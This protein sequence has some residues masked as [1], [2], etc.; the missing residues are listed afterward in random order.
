MVIGPDAGVASR[1]PGGREP[2]SGR[3]SKPRVGRQHP[4]AAGRGDLARPGDRG[5]ADPGRG[6]RPAAPAA[7]GVRCSRRSTWRPGGRPTRGADPRR[8]AVGRG[9]RGADRGGGGLVARAAGRTAA[10]DH[11]RGA[12]A[13]AAGPAGDRAAP[14]LAR[15]RT[16]SPSSAACGWPRRPL[17]VLETA[18]ELGRPGA[19]LLDRALRSWLPCPSARGVPAH[20]STA[21]RRLLDAAAER[22][23][24]AAGRLLGRLLRDAGAGGWV[25]GDRAG[26]A[27]R[28]AG[29]RRRDVPGR[30]GGRRGHRLGS[31]RWTS[32]RPRCPGR[33]WTVLCV[34]R[35]RPRRAARARCWPRSPRRSA[36]CRTGPAVMSTRPRR[37]A[38]ATPLDRGPSD[39]GRT[40]CS[41][42]PGRSPHGS[43][44]VHHVT[45]PARSGP[46]GLPVCGV[47]G[48]AGPAVATGRVGAPTAGRARR[49]ARIRGPGIPAGQQGN[50][51]RRGGPPSPPA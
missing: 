47:G 33:G 7:G 45:A 39:P 20:P 16:T 10:H 25:A 28:V 30:A 40:W 42:S 17:A 3:P 11:R 49:T 32:P 14:P 43:S 35:A 37:S 26:S 27:G 2:R 34:V 44:D 36:G 6:R 29:V 13:P 15:R 1:R 24:T 12:A 5:R 23:T 22:S 46:R 38:A 31:G 51:F 50:R 48:P 19:P 21:A 4:A 8:G 41:V 18:V 9:R